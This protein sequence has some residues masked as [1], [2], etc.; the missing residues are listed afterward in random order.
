MN[1][2]I[3][4]DL[5]CIEDLLKIN[6]NCKIDNKA[7]DELS[8]IFSKFNEENIV[9]AYL[10]D[11]IIILYVP[12]NKSLDIKN[13]TD[14]YPK[15]SRVVLKLF[16]KRMP[17]NYGETQINVIITHSKQNVPGFLHHVVS[18][19]LLQKKDTNGNSSIIDDYYNVFDNNNP[20]KYAK[21]AGKSTYSTVTTKARIK[22]YY[23]VIGNN[24]NSILTPYS[25][26]IQK[27]NFRNYGDRHFTIK[28]KIC[29]KKITKKIDSIVKNLDYDYSKKF[30]KIICINQTDDKHINSHCNEIDDNCQNIKNTLDII[31]QDKK[32]SKEGKK[33]ELFLY[34]YNNRKYFEL[35]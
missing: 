6:I 10:E 29:S 18:S 11:I 16:E 8:K 5:L 14:I 32:L 17:L 12:K 20:S 7:I 22:K 27:S 4:Y 9:K 1:E 23:N 26:L 34:I 35:L 2:I 13:V 3:K 21:K 15:E 24:S 33:T 25:E 30:L 19:A 31:N 28:C